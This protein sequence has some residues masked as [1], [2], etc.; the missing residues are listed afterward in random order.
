MNTRNGIIPAG[1][2]L[3]VAP[4]AIATMISGA[5]VAYMSVRKKKEDE[6]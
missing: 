4:F 6:E 5:G 1:I 3:A 2:M